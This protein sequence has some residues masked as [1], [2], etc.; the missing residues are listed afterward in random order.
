MRA[1]RARLL[2]A[3]SLTIGVLAGATPAR[4]TT[5]D[6]KRAEAARIASQRERL[7]AD[8]ERLNEQA[9]RPR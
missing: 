1:P 9:S 8:A 7:I 2:V 5:A 6:D 3:I 4:A